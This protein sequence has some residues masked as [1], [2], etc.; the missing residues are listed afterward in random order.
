[1][2]LLPLPLLHRHGVSLRRLALQGLGFAFQ[3]L[4]VPQQRLPIALQRH[5]KRQPARLL[6]LLPLVAGGGGKR[7]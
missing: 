2:L 1:M 4:G 5:A 6:G 3:I 7:I